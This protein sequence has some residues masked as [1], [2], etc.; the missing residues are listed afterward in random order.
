MVFPTTTREF[1]EDLDE[2]LAKA[3]GHPGERWNIDWIGGDLTYG[4]AGQA[5][6]GRAIR[7]IVRFLRRERLRLLSVE[8]L[9]KERAICEWDTDQLEVVAAGLEVG[10]PIEQIDAY[11]AALK[12]EAEGY[13]DTLGIS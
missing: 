5:L 4:P 1:L 11:F 12:R 7:Y 13:E 9:W 6:R 8:R 2:R 3:G 10:W